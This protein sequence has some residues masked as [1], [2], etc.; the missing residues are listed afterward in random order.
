MRPAGR[1]VVMASLGASG[2][3]AFLVDHLFAFANPFDMCGSFPFS[4]K[5][6]PFFLVLPRHLPAVN[7]L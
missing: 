1:G 3:P 4:H 2:L 5:M 6:S 7:K